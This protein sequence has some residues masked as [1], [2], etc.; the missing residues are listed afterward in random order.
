MLNQS[1]IRVYLNEAE[2]VTVA[3]ASAGDSCHQVDID[4]IAIEVGDLRAIA[5]ALVDMADNLDEEC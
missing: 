5:R 4:C 2:T 3:Y 1:L